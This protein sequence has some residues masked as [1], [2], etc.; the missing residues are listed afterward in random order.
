MS[1]FCLVWLS[2]LIISFATSMTLFSLGISIELVGVNSDRELSSTLLSSYLGQSLS[3]YFFS[4]VFS[5]EDYTC[6]ELGS[7][8]LR[9]YCI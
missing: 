9:Y 3:N 2:L 7:S 4:S 8:S 1:L 6:W 5:K